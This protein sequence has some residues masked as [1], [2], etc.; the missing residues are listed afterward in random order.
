[1]FMKSKVRKKV[2]IYA[3]YLSLPVDS[4]NWCID[5]KIRFGKD[6]NLITALAQLCG[7]I[8]MRAEK[9]TFGI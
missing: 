7:G 8:S 9:F 1:M 2:A 5:H 4:H 6:K 3:K